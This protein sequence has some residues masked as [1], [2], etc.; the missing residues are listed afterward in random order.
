MKAKAKHVLLIAAG[1]TFLLL[2]VAGLFL[3]V[4]QGVL[5]LLIG[6]II[7][8]SQYAWAHHW[9]QK[10]KKHFP[11]VA[12][13]SERASEKVHRWLAWRRPPQSRSQRGEAEIAE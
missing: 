12:H 6:L 11:Q 4:L 8:S 3:P 7:L 13:H 9:L 1:W 5:F 2:G 10:V